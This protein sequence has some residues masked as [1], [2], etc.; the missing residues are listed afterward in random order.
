MTYPL[1]KNKS[2]NQGHE[3]LLDHQ[4]VCNL[5]TLNLAAFVKDGEWDY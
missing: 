2:N 3:I 5:T 1:C 4:G